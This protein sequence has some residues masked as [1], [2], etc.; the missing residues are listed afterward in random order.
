MPF[1]LDEALAEFEREEVSSTLDQ[2]LAEAWK[3]FDEEE[4]APVPTSATPPSIPYDPAAADRDRLRA[5]TAEQRTQVRAER[6]ARRRNAALHPQRPHRVM[7]M[8]PHQVRLTVAFSCTVYISITI[9]TQ[10]CR[11]P[12]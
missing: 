2:T 12:Q 10:G 3:E 5:W 11:A 1:N 9:L 8:A 7:E 4:S 6:R